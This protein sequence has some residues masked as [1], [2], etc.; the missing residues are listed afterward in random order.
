MVYYGISKTET[1]VCHMNNDVNDMHYIELVRVCDDAVFCVRTCCDN[2]W[3]WRFHDTA[4]NYELVKHMIMDA[5]FDC[6]DMGELMDELD[7]IFEECFEEIL[8]NECE[9]TCDCET[10]CNHCNCDYL[11]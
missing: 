11:S 2:E 7:G 3:E 9:A 10:G 5:M 6:D 8:A 1:I 4:S